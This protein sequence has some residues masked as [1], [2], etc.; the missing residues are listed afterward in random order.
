MTGTHCDQAVRL[1]DAAMICL[2]A[3]VPMRRRALSALTLGKSLLV[4]SEQT[5]VCL[6]G[7]MTKN[8]QPWEVVVPNAAREV[9]DIYL[10]IGRPALAACAAGNHLG[11]WLGRHGAHMN[12]GQFIRAIGNRTRE[13]LGVEVPPHF[14]RD[15]AATTLARAS[16]SSAR[17]FKPVLGHS[18]TRIAEGHYILADTI[19]AGRQL[20]NVL[21]QF[22]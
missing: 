2:L 17:M 1:R 9:L 12:I 19:S 21:D 22:R 10:T 3:L 5:V 20:A 11:V 18:T 13:H 7:S 16:S 4:E 14:F 6:D 8:G 15:A